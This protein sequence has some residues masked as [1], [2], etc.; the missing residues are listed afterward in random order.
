MTTPTRLGEH[1]VE[2]PDWDC[3]TCAQPW[4]CAHARDDLLAEFHEFP[5]V[6]N[7]YMSGQMVDAARDLAARGGGP[8]TDLYDRFLSWVR[9]PISGN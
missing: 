9:P 4:P 2:R 1:I 8:P 3:R 5:S 6:L 7:I